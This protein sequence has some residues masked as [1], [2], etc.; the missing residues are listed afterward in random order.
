[1]PVE[2][3]Y[4]LRDLTAVLQRFSRRVTLEYVVIRG[5][6]DGE[7]DARALAAF[8]K[9]LGAM[10][11][12]LPLHPGGAPDLVPAGPHDM[13]RFAERVREAHVNVT[14]RRSRGTD[15][16]AA[17]GQLRTEVAVGSGVQA[18]HHRHVQ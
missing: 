9:P 4:G 11:N 7:A 12:L 16:S 1:M 17:C 5:V 10:V 18:E 8:A 14:V 6:N 2:R 13:R 15:I 3:K